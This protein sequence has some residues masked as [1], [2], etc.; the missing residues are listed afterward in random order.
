MDALRKLFA[1]YRLNRS[2]MNEA[3]RLKKSLKTW[4]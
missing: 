1:I 3:N 2:K 4:K